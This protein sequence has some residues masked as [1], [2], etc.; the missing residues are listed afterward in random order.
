MAAVVIGLAGVLSQGLFAREGDAAPPL[1]LASC[2]VDQDGVQDL[3]VGRA[4]P[5]GAFVT[6]HRLDRCS[7]YPAGCARTGSRADEPI[8]AVFDA[9]P[10]PVRLPDRPELLLAGGFDAD[11]HCDLLFA[12]R[13]SR[14][15][16]LGRGDGDGDFRPVRAAELPGPLTALAAG[17]LDREDGSLDI[18]VGVSGAAGPRVLLFDGASGLGAG[19]REAIAL[20]EAAT[21]FE[22][23]RLDDDPW[24]DLVVAAGSELLIARGVDRAEASPRRIERRAVRGAIQ[25]MALSRSVLA[26]LLADGEIAM[27]D[28]DGATAEPSTEPIRVR[29]G[30]LLR[31]RNLGGADDLWVVDREQR[32]IRSAQDGRSWGPELPGR[33]IVALPLRLNGDALSDLV[34]LLADEVSPIV[35]LSQPGVTFS[36]TNTANN[37]P[38]SLRQA[39]LD[40]NAAP[41]ADTIH[42]DIPGSGPHTIAPSTPLPAI[43]GPLTLDAT[44]QPSFTGTPV[45]ELSGSSAGTAAVGLQVTG[46]S[47]VIRGLAVNR[48][49]TGIQLDTNG[50]NVIE[51]NYIGTDLTG[52]IDLGN[53]LHGVRIVG[54]SNTVGGTS[55]EARNV[56]SG[57]DNFGVSI[58]PGAVGGNVVHGNFI[59]TDATGT[60]RI[61]NGFGVR[62]D[63]E[64]SSTSPTIIGGTAPGSGNVLSGNLAGISLGGT[65]IGIRIQ[66]NLIGTDATGT[67]DL[68]NTGEGIFINFGSCCNTIGGTTAGAGNVISGN[69]GSAIR[70]QYHTNVI[71]GNLIGTTA[72]GLGA[73]GNGLH[74]VFVDFAARHTIGGDSPGAGNTIAYNG[75]D[76]VFVRGGPVKLSQNSI[77]SNSGLGIDL[78]PVGPTPND[79]GDADGGSNGLQNFP[80]L[81]VATALDTTTSVAGTLSSRPNAT[82]TIEFLSSPSCDPSG[83][84]EGR[85]LLGTTIVNTDGGGNAAFSLTLPAAAA[86]G[87][88]VTATATDA[89]GNTSEFG[90][91]LPVACSATLPSTAPGLQ[92]EPDRIVWTASSDATVYDVVGGSLAILRSSGGDFT[93]ATD[94]CHADD[95]MAT[96]LALDVELLP[97]AGRWFLVR[98]V[99][100]AGNGTYDAGP[101]QVGQRDAEIAA[102]T[103]TCP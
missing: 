45:V 15:L 87:E 98:S 30:A 60:A 62:V 21:S 47:S 17:D 16:Y 26:A 58:S 59:G 79:P 84:G 11:G 88:V 101:S 100:C 43:S 22:F 35:I 6:V 102:A 2:D 75:G 94:T 51:G 54:S 53:T 37:G 8:D 74:G 27:W 92:V 85:V 31:A 69:G 70:S 10:Q 86:P 34:V 95:V 20:R 83:H 72:D 80:V 44:T 67:L 12:A 39:I 24:I 4:G 66:G 48:F 52:A 55:Y 13:G 56:V 63:N 1:A 91:C 23:G 82:L 93:Q 32:R 81:S 90:A 42:F 76:A 96:E 25:S 97:G 28:R 99:N 33:P 57:N 40:A 46:G 14:A 50:G 61:A 89:S 65:L 36:V 78:D 71:Q 3:V 64:A 29:D 7:I 9:S 38:G 5:G 103:A 41:G 77:F 68:G 19:A 73:L 18:A 49:E